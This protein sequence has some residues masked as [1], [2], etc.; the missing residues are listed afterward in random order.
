MN[1][2]LQAASFNIK[3]QIPNPKHQTNSKF[4]IQRTLPLIPSRAFLSALNRIL[5]GR[6][7][8]NLT[9]AFYQ[10]DAPDGANNNLITN[11][12]RERSKLMTRAKRVNDVSQANYCPLINLHIR[13]HRA[14]SGTSNGNPDLIGVYPVQSENPLVA[15]RGAR[16]N[17][18]PIAVLIGIDGKRTDPLAELYIFLDDKVMDAFRSTYI[19]DNISGGDAVVGGPVAVFVVVDKVFGAE[20]G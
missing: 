18:L 14:S 6:G 4:K 2:M 12:L 10:H 11:L 3:S 20:L 9:P 13:H 15:N 7:N 8:R 19:N 17:R 1:H 16:R 5:V